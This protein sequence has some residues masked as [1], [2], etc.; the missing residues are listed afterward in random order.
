VVLITGWLP[1]PV[2]DAYRAFI[3]YQTRVVGYF[4]LLVPTYPGGLFGDPVGPIPAPAAAPAPPQASFEPPASPDAPAFAPSGQPAVV[5]VPSP[6][7]QPWSL[8]L[9]VGAKRV[10]VLAIVLG[11]PAFVGTQVLA[12]RSSSVAHHQNL[13]RVNNALVDDINAFGVTANQCG[14]VACLEHANLVFSQQLDAFV[15]A[16]ESSDTSGVDQGPVNQVV[17][18]AQSAER[19]TAALA[20][21]GPT[22]SDY[23]NVSADD[24]AVQRLEAL[25]SAQKQYVTALNGS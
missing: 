17:A 12:N 8:I 10:L 21:S 23:R 1:Q 5:P 9:G 19:A 22:I 20:N 15:T 24:H 25:I 3:R 14:T 4:Y 2:H 6:P 16:M 7:R 18:A 13:V 11:I